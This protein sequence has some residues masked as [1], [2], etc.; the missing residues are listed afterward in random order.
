MTDIV[1]LFIC[2]C[3]GFIFGLFIAS[4][5]KGKLDGLFILDESDPSI[6]R[7]ILDVKMDPDKIKNKKDIRLKI[8][9]TDELGD[10]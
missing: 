9:M 5:S 10:V 2:S 6:T 1:L 7:W 8:C 4:I 3:V